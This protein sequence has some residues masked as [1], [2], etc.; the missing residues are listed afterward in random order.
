[1]KKF[2]LFLLAN[3]F[4]FYAS[5]C[6]VKA[7]SKKLIHYWHF[8]NTLPTNGKGGIA[9]G[10]IPADYS[11]LGNAF[12]LYKPLKGVVKDTTGILDNLAGDTINQRP[13]Y[14]GCCGSTNN[15]VRTR[16][17]SDSME[18]LWYIP[19]K[20]YQNII[21]KYE[22]QSSSIASGQHRQVFSYSTDSA[23]TFITSGL[24][25]AFDSAGTTW[26][27]VILDLSSIP[28]INNIG[29]F[30]FK[31]T[32][33]APNTGSSG[34]NRFDNI[35]VE[36][37]TVIAP[38]IT[39][40]ALTAAIINRNYSYTIVTSGNPS[41]ALSVSGNPAW[42]TLNNNILS[43]IP[44][45]I[46][47][48]GPITIM[49]SNI[50]GNTK[51]VFNLI[52]NDSINPVAPVITSSA[53]DTIKK[54]S[55][56]SYTIKVTGIPKPAISVSGNS[57]WLM[58]KDSILIGTPS[59][60]GIYGPITI[61]AT[62]ILGSVQQVFNIIVP[63]MPNITSQA[64]AKGTADSLYSYIIKLT[65]TPSPKI[66]VSGNPSW[67]ILKDSLL[68]GTPTSTGSFGPIVITADNS[69]GSIQ[70]I[71]TIVVSSCPVIT[72]TPNI[73][74]IVGTAYSYQIINTG[75]PSPVDSVIGNPAWL[76]LKN[77]ILSGTPNSS[78]LIGPITIFAENAASTAQ[79]T[80]YINVANLV[81]NT[82]GSKLIHYWHFNNSLPL[83]GSGGISY[84]GNQI[85][86]DYSRIGKAYIIFE[87]VLKN[88]RDTGY[89][90]NLLG[91]T[92]N[93]RNGYGGCC[94][95]IFNNAVRT[96][97]PSDS[98]QFLWFLPTN[99]Y[100]N[101][102]IKY[103]TQLS[104]VKSGQREQVFSYSLDSA[105][106]FI[107]TN[108][109]V[110]SNFADTSWSLVTLDFRSLSSVNDN[111]KFVLK[112]N[113]VGQ[114]TGSKG[115]NRFDNITVEGD[116]ISGGSNIAINSMDRI[117]LY[118]NPAR[119]YINISIPYNESK[120]TM[121]NSTGIMVL[122]FMFTKNKSQ[123]DI[124]QFKPGFYYI[125]IDEKKSGETKMMKFI[126]E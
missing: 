80:F 5:I 120:I 53:P 23:K 112:I 69:Q 82:S 92:I 46:D 107:T 65:G 29:S 62:N 109:P 35:T 60:D 10:T 87:P 57:S 108:L 121:Y 111:S 81:V 19:T 94:S 125:A 122:K 67:L 96:R 115:N 30:V 55:T 99:K 123:I 34:N 22:T 58:L 50:A 27:K 74:G 97:N 36:G 21:I 100:K 44:P 20:K 90:D 101:I 88:I 25:V 56:F 52:V 77:N 33:T 79:Q 45:S 91:D 24:P 72:S 11:A 28:A 8:N 66:L 12:V 37:D 114:N 26:G 15:A 110:V 113:F 51:Q 83:D 38:A 16:N 59:N 49:A 47:T 89:I 85:S 106:T 93:Q 2:I 98:M 75:T 126:K 71:F 3:L 103:E 61:T 73:S 70:Q 124:S 14:A 63:S 118:P 42:L 76:S 54:D 117:M 86:P 84:N 1:M 40:T 105:S 104:S 43:G 31:M 17:P 95:D 119:D 64:I 116:T 4:V 13:G 68:S 7:Q 39:S 102:V 48:I 18:F 41:P 32:F 6:V 9:L 78:G